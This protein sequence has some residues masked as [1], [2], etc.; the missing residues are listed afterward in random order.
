MR[1]V[2]SPLFVLGCYAFVSL[3][4]SAAL[5]GPALPTL[6][7]KANVGLDQ[8]GLIFVSMSLGYLTSAPIIS[9][10][11]QRMGTR[12][13]LIISPLLVICSMVLLALGAQVTH[14]FIATYLLGLGLS[15]TQVAY[16]ALFGAQAESSQASAVLN[17]LNAFF[18]VGALIG[19]LLV[20]A[21][22]ALIGDATLAFWVAAVMALPLALGALLAGRALKRHSIATAQP[23]SNQIAARGVFNAPAMWGMGLAMGLYVGCEVAFSGWATEFTSRMTG[24]STA[25]AAL[26][27]S[28]FWMA[29][30]L[31]RYFSNVMVSRVQPMA[32][33]TLLMLLSIAGL[34]IMMTASFAG[35]LALIGSF[36]VGFGFGPVYPTLIAIG[37]QRFP[38]A[39]QMIAS[40]L[41]SAGSIGSLFVPALTGVVMNSPAL[42][43]VSAWLMLAGLLLVIVSVWQL[44][45][46]TLIHSDASATVQAQ[47]V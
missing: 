33:V 28:A 35:A 11:G 8:V 40:V 38:F 32:L 19:P 30:A 10:F 20:A 22:Y 45:R 42:G 16:N 18:G 9:A 21:S 34:L 2:S 13:M 3:G 1:K 25:Q 29:L 27:V 26:T 31:S 23:S 44:T 5:L 46:R 36:V 7:M 15:G 43:A 24:Q 17:R 14:F 41:T 47:I 6:A 37:I 4:V 12:N 39:A